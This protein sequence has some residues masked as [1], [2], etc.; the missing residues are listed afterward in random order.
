ML[1]WSSF[2][3]VLRIIFFPSY[4]LLLHITI[5]ETTDCGEK[6]MNPVAM[7]I[8][9]PWKEYWPN[10]ESNQRPRVLKSA[11]PPTELSGLA[12]DMIEKVKFDV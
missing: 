2:N 9:N 6:G 4:W 10:R 3:P 8:I 12:T 1:S 11:R 5:V 7:T